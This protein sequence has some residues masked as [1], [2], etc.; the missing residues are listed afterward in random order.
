MLKT[1]KGKIS[2]VYIGLVLLTALVGTVAVFNTVYLRR[3]VNGL[4]A[5]N[6]I[7]I[8]AMD[9]ARKALYAQDVAVLDSVTTG[10]E[11]GI[12]TFS[13]QESDFR[14]ALEQE[15]DNITESGEKPITATLD[16]DYTEWTREFGV[17]LSRRADGNTAAAADYYSTVM[18]A[19]VNKVSADIDK[20]RSINQSSM[21]RKKSEAAAGARNALYV[22]LGISLLAVI[23]GFLLSQYLVNR[24]LRPVHLLTENIS[25]VNAGT[26]DKPLEIKT[27]DELEQLVHEFNGMLERLSSFERSTMG[28]LMEE[29]DKSVS[30]VRSI[31]DPL[32]VLDSDYRIVMANRACEKYFGFDGEKAMGK[33]FLEAIRDGELFS[34]IT[35]G[36]ASSKAVSE[37]VLKPE[38][39]SSS[40]YNVTVTKIGG[41]SN[42]VKGCIVLMQ[43][44]TGFKELEQVKTDFVAT[45]S[46]EFKTPLTSIIMGASMLE[47]GNLGVLDTRQKNVVDAIIEDGERLSGFVSELL[48][49]SRL[50]SGKAVYSFEPCS[51]SAIAWQ[52]IRQFMDSARRKNVMLLN[53]IGEDIPRVRADFERIAWVFN[54]LIS[55]AL[56]YTASGDTITVS[57]KVSGEF[58]AISV[59]DTGEGIPQEYLGKIFDKFVQVKGQDIEVGGTGL[60]LAVAKEIV[61]AHGGKI[62]VES[63]LDV[64]STFT[65]TLPLAD[66]E[67]EGKTK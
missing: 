56:K 8:S 46:H 3:S 26:L 30:I 27:G 14:R 5:E 23:G 13:E 60:G 49:V 47:G 50:E 29:K 21:Y 61:S 2:L 10:S 44:V 24:F 15:R 53:E 22:I 31:P 66:G 63:K 67:D 39:D 32:I 1:L 58:M 59:A 48:E 62:S 52:S 64:G 55:N 19:Q 4:I 20:I 41:G 6:Y 36:V 54:N 28:T 9:T 51:V 34:F 57:A 40:Y 38:N 12:N 65:F 25:K 11:S 7:S 35:A 16:A 43:D 17:F 33:H 18:R 42:D 45:V 37:K